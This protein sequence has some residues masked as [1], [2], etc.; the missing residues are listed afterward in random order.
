MFFPEQNFQLDE[1]RDSAIHSVHFSVIGKA[2]DQTPQI[3]AVLLLFP[4]GDRAG[5]AGTKES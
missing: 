1:G 5:I 3:R 2:N 4:R